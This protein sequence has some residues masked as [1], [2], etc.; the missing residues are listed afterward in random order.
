M[1]P[2]EEVGTKADVD[3]SGA[4]R[5]ARAPTKALGSRGNNKMQWLFQRHNNLSLHKYGMFPLYRILC[6]L[7]GI[8]MEWTEG[9]RL[10]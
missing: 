8:S 3:R 10:A 9:E 4:S 5:D 1:P 2:L 7:Y 6:L